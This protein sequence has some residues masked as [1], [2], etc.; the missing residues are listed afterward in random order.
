VFAYLILSANFKG[1]LLAIS[2]NLTIPAV[3]L[4]QHF[5][6]RADSHAIDT[7][8]IGH[9]ENSQQEHHLEEGQVPFDVLESQQRSRM[10][11]VRV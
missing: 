6:E 2:V 4:L 1:V 3:V 5:D 7:L 8:G 9:E 10:K 11:L